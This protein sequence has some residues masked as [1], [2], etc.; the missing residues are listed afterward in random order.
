MGAPGQD[1]QM[2]PLSMLTTS[3]ALGGAGA[4]AALPVSIFNNFYGDGTPA[5]ALRL[6]M[7]RHVN[8]DR[9]STN[10]PAGVADD[11]HA[12]VLAGALNTDP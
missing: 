12:R 1:G 11:I 5:K 4:A 9:V 3:D 6:R 8:I 2:P 10:F 7:F